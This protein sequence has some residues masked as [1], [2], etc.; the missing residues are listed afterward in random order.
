[1]PDRVSI[2]IEG[3]RE[4][5][6]LLGLGGMNGYINLDLYLTSSRQVEVS[7]Y[8]TVWYVWVGKI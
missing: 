1:M 2:G 7:Y 6:S 3:G 8:G 4:D 5:A